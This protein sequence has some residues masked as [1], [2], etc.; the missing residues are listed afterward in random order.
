MDEDAVL[1]QQCLN[2]NQKAFEVIVDRYQK[3][4]FN[5]ALRVLNDCEDAADV[6]QTAFVKAYENLH[7]FNARYKFFSWLYKI[8]VN[9][10]LNFFNQRKHFGEFDED[11]AS[12]EKTPEETYNDIEIGQ[13]IQNSIMNLRFDYRVVLVLSHFQ[14][15]SYKEI[16]YILDIPEKTVKSRLFT[17][18]QL[19]KNMLLK[20]NLAI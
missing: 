9:E 6:T 16:S 8:A 17:A 11:I 5:A 13:K 3:P 14:D 15:L 2:G 20:E 12:T 10:A 4:I 1:V 7:R 19:L 18:R